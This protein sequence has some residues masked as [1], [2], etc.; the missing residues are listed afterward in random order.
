MGS[1]SLPP[2]DWKTA[3]CDELRPALASLIEKHG[4]RVASIVE[5]LKAISI[6]IYLAGEIPPDAAREFHE[7]LGADPN[8]F[9]E[10]HSLGCRRCWCTISDIHNPPVQYSCEPQPSPVTLF[11]QL[12]DWW[13]RI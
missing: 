1:R 6:D 11:R 7:R 10:R 2:S 8:L 3:C 12:R 4:L 5:D 13:R 9:V